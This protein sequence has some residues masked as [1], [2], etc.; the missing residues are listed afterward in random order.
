MINLLLKL[1]LRNL[2]VASKKEIKV[3]LEFLRFLDQSKVLF[4]ID[5]LNIFG[6]TN[7]SCFQFS[8]SFHLVFSF[9]HIFKK[10]ILIRT[11]I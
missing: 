9:H 4:N 5:Y 2:L 11:S 8:A 10:M 1:K 7:F 3:D 6:F